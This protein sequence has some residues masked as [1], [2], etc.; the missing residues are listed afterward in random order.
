MTTK[1]LKQR[2]EKL[3]RFT[4]GKGWM[5]N[6]WVGLYQNNGS[7]GATY[8]PAVDVG[9]LFRRHFRLKKI[10]EMT[11]N[12]KHSLSRENYGE[13]LRNIPVHKGR[14]LFQLPSCRHRTYGGEDGFRVGPRQSTWTTVPADLL[15]VL[16][17]R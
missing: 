1:T 8:M 12:P 14:E 3:P 17:T 16:N 4:F 11:F 15:H 5:S 10:L 2:A 7:V 13:V 9:R 6:D